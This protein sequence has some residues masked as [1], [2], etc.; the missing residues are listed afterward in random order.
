MRFFS[1]AKDAWKTIMA[2]KMRSGLSTLGIVIGMMSVI[3]MMAIGQGAE[4]Q[5]MQQMGDLLKNNF[6]VRAGGGYSQRDEDSGGPGKYIKKVEFS[7]DIVR[8]IESY[9]SD[10]K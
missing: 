7:T 1:Y 5:V 10:L 6:S 8:Y 4:Q 9:F 3:V 2:N